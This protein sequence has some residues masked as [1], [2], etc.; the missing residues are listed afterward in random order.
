[1]NKNDSI[2]QET[3]LFSLKNICIFIIGCI[4]SWVIEGIL[5]YLWSNS[6]TLINQDLNGGDFLYYCAAIKY[7]TNSSIFIIDIMFFIV[8]LNSILLILFC[9][10]RTN[11]KTKI[12]Y[13]RYSKIQISKTSIYKSNIYFVGLF[14]SFFLLIGFSY[15]YLKLLIV[16]ANAGNIVANF[17]N[18]MEIVALKSDKLTSRQ[19]KSD[20]TQMKTRDDYLKIR[21]QIDPILK[22]ELYPIEHPG[23]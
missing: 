3:P 4:F 5:N 7:A 12:N 20:F 8:F 15:S 16:D 13:L 10:L 11:I 6:H 1:M 14:I 23:T 19:L 18:D 17:Q 2:L 9:I 21:Q 22:A